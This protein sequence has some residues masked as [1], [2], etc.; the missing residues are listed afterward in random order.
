L[1]ICASLCY[2]LGGVLSGEIWEM[3]LYIVF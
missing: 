1:T 2:S 3:Y